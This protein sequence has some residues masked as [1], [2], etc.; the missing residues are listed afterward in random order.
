LNKWEYSTKYTTY[1]LIN[2]NGQLTIG[3][4]NSLD[5]LLVPPLQKGFDVQQIDTK[6]IIRNPAA[7][8]PLGEK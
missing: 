1:N 6:N 7:D 3:I 5:S 4:K 8:W 2:E